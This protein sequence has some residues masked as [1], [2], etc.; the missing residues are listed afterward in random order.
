MNHRIT[1]TSPLASLIPALAA[2]AEARGLA[3]GCEKF[4]LEDTILRGGGYAWD[5][6]NDAASLH[7]QIDA[8]LAAKAA[9]DEAARV[10]A[11]ADAAAAALL[12]IPKAISNADLRRGLVER[13]VNPQ[14]I[15]DYL[16]ALPDGAAKWMALSDWEYAN[17]TLRAHPMLDQLAPAFGL[18]P[19]DI[20][21]IFKSKPEF[22]TF[23]I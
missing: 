16:N 18:T 8:L 5:I 14:L 19:A 2:I 11:Q 6:G 12:Y 23:G 13:G 22:H 20:D 3:A 10:Q 21:A 17:Y 4:E 15:T 1:P 9:A 7:A